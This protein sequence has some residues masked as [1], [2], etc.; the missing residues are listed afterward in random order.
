MIF[1][2]YFLGFVYASQSHIDGIR[3]IETLVR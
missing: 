2:L 3:Q 1:G